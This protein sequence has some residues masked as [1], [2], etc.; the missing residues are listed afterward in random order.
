MA[1]WQGQGWGVTE[2]VGVELRG[3]TDRSGVDGGQGCC[4]RERIQERVCKSR[5]QA[6]E[7]SGCGVSNLGLRRATGRKSGVSG[8]EGHLPGHGDPSQDCGT[9]LIDWLHIPLPLYHGGPAPWPPTSP[10]ESAN[11][12]TLG[13]RRQGRRPPFQRKAEERREQRVRANFWGTEVR[14]SEENNVWNMLKDL[15]HDE[16]INFFK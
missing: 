14:K 3:Q 15:R 12:S 6:R 4:G 7:L 9:E 16:I 1:T 10:S 11:A 8:A 2:E 5:S 13:R